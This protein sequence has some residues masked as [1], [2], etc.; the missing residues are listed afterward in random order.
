[1][2]IPRALLN[3]LFKDTRFPLVRH[4]LDSYDDFLFKRIP[5]LLKAS[6]PLTLQLGDERAIRIFMGGRDGDAVSF[7]PPKDEVGQAVV[8]HICRLDRRTYAIDVGVKVVIEYT[9]GTQLIVTEIENFVLGKIPLMLRSRPCYLTNLEPD[10]AYRMGECRFE[11]G[12]YFIIGGSERALLTQE[13]LGNNMYYA[14]KRKNTTSDSGGKRTL[15]EHAPAFKVLTPDYDSETEVYAAIRSIS[16]D[17]A[18]GPYSHFMILPPRTLTRRKRLALIQLPGYDQPVPLLAVFEALGVVTDKDLYDTILAGV[19]DQERTSYDDLLTELILSFLAFKSEMDMTSAQ[20]LAS[21]TRTQSE[22]QVLVALHTTLF[23][24]VE[25]RGDDSASMFRRKAYTLGHLARLAI[26]L[27]LDKTK[28]S[29][30]EHFKYKRLDSSGDLYFQQFKRIYK[31]IGRTMLTLM[32]KRLTYEAT[33]YAGTK[34]QELIQ[35][36]TL[37]AFW[38]SRNFLFEFEKAHK[39]QWGGKDGVSQELSRLSFYST[40]SQLR[41]VS[42]QMD[43]ALNIAEPRRLHCSQYGLMCPTDSPDGKS[44]GFIKAFTTLAQLATPSPSKAVLDAMDGLIPLANVRPSVWSP[45]WTRVFL[46]A[47]LVGLLPGDAEVF[48]TKLMR[49]RR[50]GQLDKF[51]SL[52][53]NRLD[54]VYQVFTDA[55]RPIRP[56]YREGVSPASILAAKTWQESEAYF[57]WIDSGETETTRLSMTSF[58]KNLSSEIH[59]SFNYAP[60][61]AAVPFSDHNAGTRNMFSSAQQ[62]KQ[63]IG[64]YHTNFKKRFDTIATILNAPQRPL[65][66]TWMYQH[67]FG[68]MP[69]G[70]NVMVAI[71]VYSGFNQE[72]SVLVN[73]A[74][75][76]RGLFDT[77]YYHSYKYEEELVDHAMQTHTQTVNLTLD[78]WADVVRKD[79]DYSKLDADGIV[80]EGETIESNTVLI[81]FVSPVSNL[82]GIVESYRDVSVTPKRGQRGRVDAVYRYRTTDGLLGIQIRL[83]EKRSP[84]LGDKFASRHG[85][86]GTIG[87]IV[88]EEDMPFT[89]NGVRPD[90]VVNPHAIPTRMTVG[91]LLESTCNKLGVNRGALTDATPFT[92]NNRIPDTAR[93]MT[94]MGYEPYGNELLYNGYT[95][96]MFDAPIFI[97]PTFYMRLKQMVEDK[98]NYRD[99]GARQRMTHQPPEGRGNDGGLRIGEMERDVLLAHGIS[100]F[101]QESMMKRSDGETIVYQPETGLLTADAKNVQGELEMPYTMRLFAQE[102]QSMHV[103]VML[104]TDHPT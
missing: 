82:E 33:G 4:H 29:D 73:R 30:R 49:A 80:R 55:G 88:N 87:A 74:S 34:I 56:V 92:V 104:V 98:I 84:T 50:S 67:A 59:P 102:I 70:Q 96:E 8:P 91:Q 77:T 79:A 13:V 10:E 64:W 45:D 21:R 94:E 24:H 100:A 14:G 93:L 1:M 101:A 99:T 20:M 6:N 31:E 83:A 52:S 103:S 69:Y 44:I 62:Q 48:H 3:R 38:S 85:Q 26:D 42:L 9:I 54:N 76:K 39:S 78:K 75:L 43:K 41:R 90:I 46:N 27:S 15:I 97:G 5:A 18:T 37:G 19:P 63:A 58:D 53:W 86:K 17:G 66:Q 2:E 95:G 81:G 7:T 16:E 40:L 22:S 47:D 11:L 32:D 28:P 60:S 25:M 35:P 71:M 89:R 61:A 51:V 36:E 12:G 57:D 23:P 65:A 68:C 72:D